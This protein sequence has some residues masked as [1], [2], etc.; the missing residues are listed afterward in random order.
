MKTIKT[1]PMVW[2]PQNSA[3]APPIDLQFIEFR[4]L[5]E[6]GSDQGLGFSSQ[7]MQ[8]VPCTSISINELERNIRWIG[9][10]LLSHLGVEKNIQPRDLSHIS[11]AISSY[12][13]M[14]M[15]MAGL[16]RTISENNTITSLQAMRV[17]LEGERLRHRQLEASTASVFQ[18]FLG[19]SNA[20]ELL[21]SEHIS[22]AERTWA[23]FKD[24][25]EN[26]ATLVN[27]AIADLQQKFQNLS[28]DFGL[29]NQRMNMEKKTQEESNARF[30]SSLRH[31]ELDHR[32]LVLSQEKSMGD[33]ERIIQDLI[34]MLHTMEK[35]WSS[36]HQV[37]DEAARI[38]DVNIERR[39][40]DHLQTHLALTE[41]VREEMR[42]LFECF[43]QL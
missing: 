24:R 28:I 15:N 25:E 43:Y 13:K 14:I 20:V 22:E 32:N 18:A 11:A 33:S 12:E 37:Y 7:D 42:R 17:E 9:H 29:Q 36:R 41:N 1:E 16:H 31:L 21:F 10:N 5:F 35:T 4:H 39:L 30:S 40:A 19:K 3:V 23:G 2:S 38:R 8:A 27:Q 6:E 34:K 26:R